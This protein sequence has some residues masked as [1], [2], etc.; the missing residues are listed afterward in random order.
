MRELKQ[1]L[2]RCVSYSRDADATVEEDA[3][4]PL[5]NVDID[6]PIKA[7]R[8]EWIKHFERQYLAKVLEAQ[9]GNV[10]RA[11]RR[12]G[13]DRGHFYRLMFRCGLRQS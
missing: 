3:I 1:Y 11:A 5:P 13:V 9:D 4:G 10:T 6:R 2:E 7:G 8:E 12:A